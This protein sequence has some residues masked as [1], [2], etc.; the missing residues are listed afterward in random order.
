MSQGTIGL[1][2]LAP[3]PIN[4][5]TKDRELL[6]E[7]EAFGVIRRQ[8]I[9][10]LLTLRHLFLE[11][12]DLPSGACLSPIKPTG[13]EEKWPADF[14]AVFVHSY[15]RQHRVDVPVCSEHPLDAFP[16]A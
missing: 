9:P 6:L 5:S 3:A 11:F 8:G 16:N 13:V 15:C 10:L 14:L 7:P 1:F 12:V 2:I 4:L